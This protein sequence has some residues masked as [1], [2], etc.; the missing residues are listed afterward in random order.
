MYKYFFEA[1]VLKFTNL[2]SNPKEY[3]HKKMDLFAKAK[4]QNSWKH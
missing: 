2:I 1:Q 3:R 4:P